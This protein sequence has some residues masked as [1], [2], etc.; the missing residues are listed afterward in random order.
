MGLSDMVDKACGAQCARPTPNRTTI[1]ND[2]L[3]LT[4][5]AVILALIVHCSNA[6]AAAPRPRGVVNRLT[7]DQSEQAPDALGAALSRSR[8]SSGADFAQNATAPALAR[9]P[10][11]TPPTD[12]TKFRPARWTSKGHLLG[13]LRGL[14]VGSR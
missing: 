11:A 8:R 7:E 3:L 13:S 10:K 9:F 2:G 12:S 6:Q 1:G 14:F 4:P 5:G